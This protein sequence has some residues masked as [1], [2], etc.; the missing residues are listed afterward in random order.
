MPLL[1]AAGRAAIGRSA[2]DEAIAHLERARTLLDK[3]DASPERDRQEAVLHM[4][5]GN[6]LI[7]RSGYTSPETHE[8]FKKAYALARK[9]NDPTTLPAALYGI[10]V[11]Q[12]MGAKYAA[13][14]EPAGEA[15]TFAETVG[16]A[17]L[18]V[19]AHRMAGM[20]HG[21]LGELETA[22]D[23]LQT[24]VDLYDPSAHG[25][26]A[27]AFGQDPGVAAL[28]NLSLLRWYL[29]YTEQAFAAADQAIALAEQS[30]HPQTLTYAH[31]NRAYFDYFREDLAALDI[32]T[33]RTAALAET[34]RLG[35]YAGLKAPM[36]AWLQANAGD[37]ASV[38]DEYKEGLE[39]IR[40]TGNTVTIAVQIAGL[41]RCYAMAGRKDEA[42][43]T[44]NRTIAEA[45]ACEE[46]YSLPFL[47]IAKAD[48]ALIAEPADETEAEASFRRAI[49]LAQVQK[50]QAWRLRA[51]TSLA[52][53]W[54]GQGKDRQ[55]YALLAPVY[56]WFTE[57]F[58][59]A[60]LQRAKTLLDRLTK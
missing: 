57:G 39:A 44:I 27:L 9:L 24:A 20:S 54:R 31:S 59:S 18:L 19:V 21:A 41:A 7:P 42:M 30:G 55:A 10:W 1:V 12:W 25:R 48:C 14:I 43:A 26:L 52:E 45:E 58:D 5:L 23:H 33:R 40:R 51:V 38:L 47:Y 16:D 22:R 15:L 2:G 46:N 29:G 6:A 8:A 4:M 53:L 17:G 37:P 34:H 50:N 49:D 28:S 36:L 60:A 56:E 35:F 32:S 3:T 13:S 11:N